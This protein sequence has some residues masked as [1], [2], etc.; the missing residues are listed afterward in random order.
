MTKMMR[1]TTKTKAPMQ[2]PITVLKGIEFEGLVTVEEGEA[3]TVA[4]TVKRA[5]VGE[6]PADAP[7]S[8]AKP[9]VATAALIPSD[10]PPIPEPVGMVVGSILFARYRPS[11]T[12]MMNVWQRRSGLKV[13]KVQGRTRL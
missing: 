10:T 3:G 7:L 13:G 8:T 2:L 5:P 12:N 9:V 6:G 1:A 11:F 4:I